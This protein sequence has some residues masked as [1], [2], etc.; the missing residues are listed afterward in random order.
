MSDDSNIGDPKTVAP[1]G[2]YGES[3]LYDFSKFVTTLSLLAL[4]GVLSLTQAADR[5]DVKLV[6]ILLVLGSISL[7]GVLALSVASTLAASRSAGTEPPR[8]PGKAI[9]AAMGLLGVGTGAFL[10]IWWDMLT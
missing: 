1:D 4:G 5:S 9:R 3:L 10:M 6:N 2:L 8:W 7:A